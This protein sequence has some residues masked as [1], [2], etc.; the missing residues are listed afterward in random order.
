MWAYALFSSIQ[1]FL[2]AQRIV[3]P[4]AVGNLLSALLHPAVTY[5]LI[6]TV[7]EPRFE[8]LH[9]AIWTSVKAAGMP[10]SCGSWLTRFCS[11]WFRKARVKGCI[12]A[13]QVHFNGLT[14]W[15]ATTAVLVQV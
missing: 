5:L 6:N 2:Q 11:S 15:T 4:P 14:I 10:V 12:A 8:V 13:V 1:G 7:G 9:V 3:N